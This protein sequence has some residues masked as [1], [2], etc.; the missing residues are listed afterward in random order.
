VFVTAGVV[1]V[2]ILDIS[3]FYGYEQL[4]ADTERR[5]GG[6]DP[7]YT[8][9]AGGLSIAVR[10]TVSHP[11]PESAPAHDFSP[12]ACTGNRC[13]FRVKAGGPGP[14]YLAGSFNGWR[15]RETALE[16]PDDEGFFETTLTLPPGR[17][18]YVF[19][20]NGKPLVPENA[21]AYAED[22]FGTRSAVVTVP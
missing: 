18:L 8:R 4:F 6:Y 9:H 21:E 12:A 7:S 14:V 5:H 17:H 20:S 13:L 15:D 22:E 2:P 16:G 11:P 10:W 1:P 19:I 3:L